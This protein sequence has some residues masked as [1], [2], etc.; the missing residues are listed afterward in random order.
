[1]AVGRV[2]E[3][4]ADIERALRLAPNDPH[5]LALQTIIAVVQHEKD[6]ALSVAQ[7]AVQAAKADLGEIVRL[8]LRLLLQEFLGSPAN[9]GLTAAD[10]EPLAGKVAP[11]LV[12]G[13]AV[14]Q[15]W[16]APE[17][18]VAYA[19]TGMSVEQVVKALAVKYR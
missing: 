12:A 9:P 18:P 19:E 17:G 7:R 8:V 11:T 14:E 13:A 2:D 15:Y 3:A 6:H 16:R 4:S 1:M 5:A 10:V